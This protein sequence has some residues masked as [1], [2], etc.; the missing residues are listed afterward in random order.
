MNKFISIGNMADVDCID[1]LSTLS[2][3]RHE[4]DRHVSEGYPDG[5]RLMIRCP[6]LPGTVVI[7]KVGDKHRC[8]GAHLIS[9]LCWG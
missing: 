5:R 4:G 9:G 2:R 1:L 3:M 7:P 6:G 8:E